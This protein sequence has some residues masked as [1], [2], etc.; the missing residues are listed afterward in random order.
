MPPRI[1]TGAVCALLLLAGP[2]LAGGPLRSGPQVGS[3]NDRQGFLP[4]W[5]SGP[6]AGKR[7]CPV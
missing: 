3:A 7:L 5:V 6:S 4:Q 1:F 2:A